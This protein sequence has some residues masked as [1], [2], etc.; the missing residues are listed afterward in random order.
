M[1]KSYIPSN[2]TEGSSFRERFC[3]QCKHEH[4]YL[5]TQ[6]PEHACQIFNATLIYNLGDDEYPKE[7]IYAD[8]NDIFSGTCTAFIKYIEPDGIKQEP[9]DDVTMDLFDQL[10]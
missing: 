2:G 6:D 5:E 8:G 9:K 10:R 3:D 1:S 7:W 4:E